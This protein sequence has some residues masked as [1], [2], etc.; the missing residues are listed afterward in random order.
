[1]RD[2]FHFFFVQ[3]GKLHRSLHTFKT[4]QRNGCLKSLTLIIRCSTGSVKAVERTFQPGKQVLALLPII[5]AALQARFCGPYTV[6]GKLSDTDYVTSTPDRKQKT[7]LCHIKMLKPYY[8]PDVIITSPP[9]APVVSIATVPP[10]YTKCRWI[11]GAE[12]NLIHT[13]MV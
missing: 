10:Q 4:S 5:G 9:V 8:S 7:C 12:C 2:V 11:H 3:L 1:M 13:E 6:D